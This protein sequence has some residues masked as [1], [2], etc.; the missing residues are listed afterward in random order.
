MLVAE[1]RP[2]QA[3]PR[4]SDKLAMPLTIEFGE[5][6]PDGFCAKAAAPL[7][8]VGKCV[9]DVQIT[10]AI[11]GR[12]EWQSQS[13]LVFMPQGEWPAGQEYRVAF[14][15]KLFADHARV[16]KACKFSTEPLIIEVADLKFYQDLLNPAEQKVVAAV[17]FNCAVDAKSFEAKT[18]LA[19]Q[20]IDNAHNYPLKFWY[21]DKG[22]TAYICSDPIMLTETPRYAGLVI[23]QGVKCAW[24]PSCTTKAEKK[25]LLIP[26]AD[27][28]LQIEDVSFEIEKDQEGN[29][30][31]VL[32]VKSSIGIDH[33]ELSKHVKVYVLPKD[34]PERNGEPS[35]ENYAW[36]S[37]GEVT[38][39]V[40]ALSAQVVL[41]SLKPEHP[42]F[43]RNRIKCH[44]NGHVYL[45]IFKGVKGL[46]GFELAQ[47]YC[48]VMQAPDY[49]KKVRFV[50]QGALMSAARDK[51]I[52]VAAA[53]VEEVLFSI[54]QVKTHQ[55]YHL[56]TQT[57]GNFQNPQFTSGYFDKR[58]IS[59]LFTERR[60]L[61]GNHPGEQQYVSLDFEP[62][63]P[64]GLFLLQVQG[65]DK[66]DESLM[67]VSDERLILITDLGLLVKDNADHSHEVFVQSITTG[68][69][70]ENVKVELLGR[71]GEA[72]ASGTTDGD[73]H[74]RIPSMIGF[75][76]EKAPVAYLARR[77]DEISFI[78]YRRADRELKY[79]RFNIGGSYQAREK[80][81]S[82]YLFTDRGLYRPEEDVKIGII[83]KEGFAG[84]LQEEKTFEIEIKDPR[85]TLVH[86][87][88]ISS[89]EDYF[90]EE[91]F[92]LKRTAN[93]GKYEVYLY[94]HESDKKRVVIGTASFQ[95][96]EFA[97]DLLKMETCFLSPK[98][99]SS[100]W[101]TPH[102]LKAKV[103][104][105]NLF[106][107]PAVGSRVKGKM[108]VLSQPTHLYFS[109]YP[110]YTFV[111]PLHDP[112]MKRDYTEE[113]GEAVVDENGIAYIDLHLNQF[114]E[115]AYQVELLLEGFEAS[116]GRAVC[117]EMRALISP[118]EYVVGYKVEEG[119]HE[120]EKGRNYPIHFIA[121]TSDLNKRT[122]EGL[123]L[124]LVEDKRV[125]SLQKKR[126]GTF[127]YQDEIKEKI[128][129]KTAFS[130]GHEG[131]TIN[132]PTK[133]C[134]NFRL[135][136]MDRSG[137]K[138]S[139]YHFSVS[140][141]GE[142]PK[143]AELDLTLEK[144]RLKA[145]DEIKMQI[146]APYAGCGLI[147]IEREKVYAYKWFKTEGFSSE[148]TITIPHD[149][150]GDGYVNMAFI[151]AW[152]VD[153]SMFNPFSYAVQPFKLDTQKQALA[154]D[155]TVPTIVR[156]GDLLQVQYSTP[157]TAK[158]VIFAV[159]EGILQ[160]GKY[161]TPDPLAYF[162][163]K[164]ALRVNTFQ[165]LDL[166]LPKVDSRRLLSSTGGDA[167]ESLLT[168][169]LNPFKAKGEPPCAFWSGIVDSDQE[170]KT[171]SF[172]VPDTFN[173]TLRV[174][175]VAVSKERI[176]HS[177]KKVVA[178]GGFVITPSV[179]TFVSP[180]DIFTISASLYKSGE[181]D[182]A[183]LTVT[184]E[185]PEE[186]EL[187]TKDPYQLEMGAGQQAKVSFTLKAGNRLKDVLCQLIIKQGDC[188][189][190]RGFT[191]NVRPPSAFQTTFLRGASSKQE[192]WVKI[193]RDLYP[194]SRT[195]KAAISTSPIL[196]T[197]GL[198]T[199][200]NNYPFECTE[201]LVS[202]AFTDMINVRP[203]KEA[204][205]AFEFELR[206]R[207]RA[208]GG[209]NYFP[210]LCRESSAD[211]ASVYVI[212]YLVEAKE[213]GLPVSVDLFTS[214]LSYLHKCARKDVCN[215]P[216]ARFKAYAIYLLTRSGTVTTNYLTDLHL[217][218][219]DHPEQNLQADLTC[220]YMAAIYRMLQ[221]STAADQLLKLYRSSKPNEHDETFYNSSVAHAISLMLLTRHFPEE[222]ILEQS[223]IDLADGLNERLNT[224]HAAYAL[225]AL[226][227]L[228]SSDDEMNLVIKAKKGD[229]VIPLASDGEFDGET[230]ALCFS[231]AG[232]KRP[233]FYQV[234]MTGF[235]ASLPT[236]PI[237]RGLEIYREYLGEKGRPLH[238]IKVGEKMTACL[239]VRTLDEKTIDEAVI[240]DLIPG[241]FEVV[242]GSVEGE[243][244]GFVD[245]REDRVIFYCSLG[246]NV[247]EFK[248][249]LRAIC[250]GEYMVPPP[251]AQNMYNPHMQAQ[252]VS[253]TF[254]VR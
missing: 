237:K 243:E 200:L 140:C 138:L 58:D 192:A 61:R 101:Y 7:Q 177:Q 240:V 108:C 168:M 26:D 254:I 142:E 43:T 244:C 51:K 66:T 235:D 95:V 199:Y 154:I 222:T 191:I 193:T 15:D 50:E 189:T 18:T 213:K 87:A 127:H 223:W 228:S 215:L 136:V 12:W 72:I 238:E 81:I 29:S 96:K 106:G 3:V 97:P 218:M 67:D 49:P 80:Q 158:I 183:P 37:A 195:L 82:G 162:F 186:F 252:G 230:E 33:A 202:R 131:T 25:K 184:L 169:N 239:K 64:N 75:K 55:I 224:L 91:G 128:I 232:K 130:I 181:G 165:I 73:G 11:D 111:D 208:D 60:S 150:E 1:V 125:L 143:S 155:L 163:R 41:E 212:D 144:G 30:Y 175:A 206:K 86:K 5:R 45:H 117:T 62:Y 157:E 100:A 194:D 126:D 203:S 196:L 225:R 19:L 120:L 220:L 69:P 151:R 229:K 116:G 135:V 65:W 190:E 112:K 48:A 76:D 137:L 113:L 23:E 250:P 227:A 134:G 105:W 99:Q 139:T 247:A 198:K 35:K 217:Y 221:K 156:P 94:V 133:R 141:E 63:H 104:L 173:G 216:E 40:R 187:L 52:T 102:D 54:S 103:S 205:E 39:Q 236:Q 71:N 13:R 171:V 211:M 9:E 27:S 85:G 178:Q 47:D 153:H 90:F 249:Q 245:V 241:G 132:I 121:L 253:G 251:F 146:K 22:R 160:V 32:V 248:Y 161:V 119:L 242:S 176:G 233:V 179:P 4:G 123:K 122:V 34:Y 2:P 21:A 24:G 234:E 70:L 219:V 185:C 20:E 197:Q 92:N 149:F 46:G 14:Q 166:I 59:E 180:G 6:R 214:A 114:Q 145:G 107:A 124:L 174:M 148:Q 10:P 16:E 93:T 68:S 36:R 210:S 78:P 147:T 226:S 42:H 188:I 207:G 170:A 182:K 118:L 77:G 44:V 172:K 109:E 231:N 110:A 201:Q 53:G 28:M 74:V 83:V 88:K 98:N 79:S 129:K 167:S 152:D 159:D 204:Y 57:Y 209:F 89:N 84:P 17:H 31:Q 115:A 8:C 164:S 38:E 56:V 246:S